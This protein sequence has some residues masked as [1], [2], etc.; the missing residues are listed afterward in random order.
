[1]QA[2]HILSEIYFPNLTSLYYS[3][4][5]GNIRFVNEIQIFFQHPAV[6]VNPPPT[7]QEISGRP[8][9]WFSTQQVNYWSYI[10]HSS[11]TW[12]KWEYYESVHQLFI[13]FQKAYG[14]DRTEVLYNILIEFGIT[15]EPDKANEN[16]SEWRQM[17][18]SGRQT[19]ISHVSV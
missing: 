1:M 5:Q 11:K 3:K 9:V 10:V 13:D 6:K 16:V 18:N 14:P 17:H 4:V 12:E 2:S 19:F 15:M 7:A 8:S